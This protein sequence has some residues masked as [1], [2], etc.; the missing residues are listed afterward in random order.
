MI[1]LW[2]F[3]GLSAFT[4]A[5]TAAFFSITGLGALYAA[6]F[7]PVVIMASSIEMGKIAA[8]FW[9]H[10]NYKRASKTIIVALSF[11]VISAMAITSGG[12][13]GF[14]TKGH[15]DQETPII[16]IQLRIDRL[17]QRITSQNDLVQR[18]Q[19][20]LDQLD[21]VIDTLIEYDK[22]SREDGARA[23]RAGQQEER[24]AIQA[25]IDGAYSQIETLNDQ[26]LPLKQGVAQT[27][28]KLGPV[29]YLAALFGANTQNTIIYFTLL[30]V[31]LLDPF[32]ILLI[33]ATSISYTKW[34]EINKPIAKKKTKIV[35]KQY[36]PS[37]EEM[38]EFL[39]DP[40]VQ[41]ELLDDPIL[42]DSVEDIINDIEERPQEDDQTDADTT[43]GW[44]DK[45]HPLPPRK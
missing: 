23:V 7:I 13:Y 2:I 29:K 44:Y 21:S 31:L 9:L 16:D 39:E 26:R 45:N 17:D 5:A 15:I 20:R 34:E 38:V 24:N 33:I 6:A 14:L 25:S 11:L 1:P 30:I 3:T 4:L 27:E 36:S 12:V 22:I 40:K 43:N 10:R 41:E 35:V 37:K 32:A 19:T 28:A 18:E 8:T 42:L